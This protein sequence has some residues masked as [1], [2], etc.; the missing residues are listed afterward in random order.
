MKAENKNVGG[1]VVL[2]KPKK[3][4]FKEAGGNDYHHQI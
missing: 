4:Q 3:R 2:Q 1:C